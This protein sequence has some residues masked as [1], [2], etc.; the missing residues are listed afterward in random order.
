MMKININKKGA[1]GLSLGLVLAASSVFA[2]NSSPAKPV[3]KD[4]EAQIVPAFETPDKW[5]RQELWVETT[6]DTDGDGKL[7]RM[8]V[9]VTRPY[10]TETEGLKL[11]I[12]YE[13]SPYYTGTLGNQPGVFWDVKH[14]VGVKPPIARTHHEVV[15]RTPKPLS[16]SQEREWIRRGFIVVH[17]SSPGTGQ[18]DGSPTVGGKNESLAPKAVIE[19]LAGKDNGYTARVGGEKVKAFW[20]TGKVGM[21][22][23]SYVGTL[24]LAAATTGVEALKAIIPVAPNTS[25]YHYYRSNGLIRNPGGYPGEDI[26]VLYDYIHSGDPSKRAYNNK[27]VRDTELANGMDR[28]TGDYNDF[29]AGRDYVNQMKPMKA[30]LLM[31]HGFNDWNVMPEHSYRVYKEAEKMGLPTQI[32]YHQGGH[33]GPPPVKMMNRW[34]T[35]FLFDVQ[36]GVEKDP[37]AWITREGAPQGEPTP[38]ANFPNPAASPVTLYLTKGGNE[39][40]NLSTSKASNQGTEKLIDDVQFSGKDLAMSP[41]SDNRLLYVSPVLKEAVHLSGLSKISVKLSSSKPAANFSVWLVSLPWNEEKT[42]KIYENVI[43]RGWADPQ[44]HKS[45]RKGEPLVPG[46]FV[47]LTFELQP[48]DQII[49][50]GKQIG[51]MIF[52]SDKEFTLWPKAGT[53]IT[54]DLNGTSFTIP[55]V[56]GKAAWDK[57]TK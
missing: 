20:S 42:A 26:D 57:A 49:P 1:I 32:Y 21:T 45:I 22:G 50:A 6:F 39:K 53:E 34:F 31:S 15:T 52:S 24:P 51:L 35:R 46:K 4:G 54:I 55:V 43:T 37:K 2:Q 12:I 9:T 27:T 30:A 38:Y 11:P 3:I 47:D 29:W 17:S 10:Q 8:H 19:W 36:N 33:G 5:I 18:S 56:G 23:T 14:E 25:Y 44:N 48:D 28:T 13:T 40:G 7:D 41:K 16:T